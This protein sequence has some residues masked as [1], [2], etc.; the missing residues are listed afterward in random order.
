[1]KARLFIQKL[2]TYLNSRDLL[3]ALKRLL[4]KAKI[5]IF[6]NLSKTRPYTM[7]NTNKDLYN[8]PKP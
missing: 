8:L 2:V 7:H 5:N 4:K 6:R 1:M 3:G